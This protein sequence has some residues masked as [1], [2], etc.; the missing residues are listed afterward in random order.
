[1][2]RFRW[3]GTPGEE[4]P[5]VGDV[6]TSSHHVGGPQ[7][8]RAVILRVLSAR[9][10]TRGPNAHRMHELMLTVEETDVRAWAEPNVAHFTFVWDRG[11]R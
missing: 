2:K 4:Q 11:G 5:D 3:H 10:L 8:G 9:V 6:L 1:V 7:I